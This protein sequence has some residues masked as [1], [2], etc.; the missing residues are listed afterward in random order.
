M[1][2]DGGP[3]AEASVLVSLRKAPRGGSLFCVPIQS[4]IVWLLYMWRRAGHKTIVEDLGCFRPTFYLQAGRQEQL[5]CGRYVQ[6]TQKK[7]KQ[8]NKQTNTA[9]A[10]L[11]WCLRERRTTASQ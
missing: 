4:G 6:K 2:W 7:K 1:R 8:Q 3:F 9:C 11:R 5:A 10:F